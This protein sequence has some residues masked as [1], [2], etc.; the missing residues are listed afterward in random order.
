MHNINLTTPSTGY[1]PFR[2]PWAYDYWLKQQQVHWLPE[3]V[4]MGKDVQDW[5]QKLTDEER[6]LLTQIFRFFTQADIEVQDNYMDKY[7]VIF[8]PTEIKM[9]L[10]AFTNMET[11]HIAGYSH[12]LDTIGMP[13]TEYSA[14]L[15]YGAMRDKSDFLHT[16]NASSPME[17]A[18]TLAVF[19]AFVEG[20]QLFASFAMLMNFPRFN[21]MTGMGQIISWS[22]RDESLHCEG[23]IRLFKQYCLESFG[24]VPKALQNQI[25]EDMIQSVAL[26]DNFI[27]L[28]FSLGPVEGMTPEEVK[29]YIR[30]TADQRLGE[31]GFSAHYG[32][33]KH[34]L[35]WLPPL[36]TGQEHANFFEQR[37][38]E[39]S[40]GA[41]KGEWS[42]VWDVFDGLI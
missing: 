25:I 42:K 2:Y 7:A 18:R 24:G 13:E 3:E 12:L 36:I 5:L 22:I 20:L 27:D 14:F 23:M 39:Y 32:V 34:P 8:K 30:F 35:P 40:K 16:F 1:K 11:V 33:V 17:T 6:N 15:E 26:E 37:A 9:M 28:A 38:T 19:A 31:L 4:P 41:T 29:Q 21:K 10:A